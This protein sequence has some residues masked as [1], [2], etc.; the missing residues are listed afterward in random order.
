MSYMDMSSNIVHA[1]VMISCIEMSSDAALV[2]V[3]MSHMDIGYIK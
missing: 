2:I 1:S 3:V